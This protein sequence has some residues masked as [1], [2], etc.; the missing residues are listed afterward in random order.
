MLVAP[1]LGMPLPLLPLQILWVNL[2][3]DGF[4]A[5]A[6]G[7]EPAERDIMRRLP[8]HP[9]ENI[10]GRG[11]GRHILWVGILMALVV[12]GTGRWYWNMGDSRWQTMVF[13][14]LIVSQL[15]HVLAI[16][17]WRES[18]FRIGL[19]SNK[20]LLGAVA[21]TLVLQLAVVYVP[22]LQRVFKTVP[23]SVADLALCL[24]LASVVF[25]AVEL[26]KWL[27]RSSSRQAVRPVSSQPATAFQSVPE[28]IV[29]RSAKSRRSM[30]QAHSSDSSG[31]REKLNQRD[32][33]PPM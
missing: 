26:E 27:L 25:W 5:L 9:S 18:T 14:V 30:T 20:P 16:R 10:F 3:T 2:V 22:V 8:Y 6:L 28:R 29:T 21:V 4:P 33:G 1:L 31:F 13:M 11:L 32:L 23:L 19:L 7:V 24:A 17:S 15:S 12:I